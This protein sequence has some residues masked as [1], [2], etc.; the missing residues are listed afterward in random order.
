MLFIES[1]IYGRHCPTYQECISKQNGHYPCPLVDNILE[2]KETTK[3]HT[4]QY[5]MPTVVRAM[6]K[7]D[8]VPKEF[9]QKD[10]NQ[11]GK[12]GQSSMRK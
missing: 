12:V 8:I 9:Q 7:R 3:N 6:E 11:S 1:L 5:K 10:L 4:T 2:P